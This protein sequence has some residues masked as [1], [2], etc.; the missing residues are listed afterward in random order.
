MG[1]PLFVRRGTAF[2]LTERGERR[3]PQLR[4][5]AEVSQALVDDEEPAHVAVAMP[6]FLCGVHAGTIARALEPASIRVIE[7]AHRT[8]ETL[9]TSAHFEMAVSAGSLSM[10]RSWSSSIVGDVTFAPFTTP[11]RAQQLGPFATRE[12]LAEVPFVLPVLMASGE[13]VPGDDGCSIP[14]AARKRGHEADTVR[15]ALD[16]AAH[17]GQVVYAPVVAAEPWVERGALVRVER[18][19]FMTRLPLVLHVHA[20]RVTARARGRVVVA[21]RDATDFRE[22]QGA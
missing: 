22:P 3:L 16:L 6:S 13:V 1:H 21:L 4:T 9:A 7:L 12:D 8:I 19:E 15:A 14:R 18:A 17:T 11:G 5:F 10:P 20:E 2:R